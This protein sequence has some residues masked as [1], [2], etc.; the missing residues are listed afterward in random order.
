MGGRAR[1]PAGQPA[2]TRCGNTRT[3]R[4]ATRKEK[5]EVTQRPRTNLKK[6]ARTLDAWRE[7]WRATA[8]RHPDAVRYSAG[9]AAV[10]FILGCALTGY[11]YVAFSRMIDA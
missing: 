2:A 9:A 5:A 11:Y 4:A 8:R 10:I 6:A 1:P 7:R 3:A